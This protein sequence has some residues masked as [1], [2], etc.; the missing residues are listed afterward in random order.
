MG[1]NPKRNAEEF[2]FVDRS[3][4]EIQRSFVQQS[5]KLFVG[6]HRLCCSLT[7]ATACLHIHGYSSTVIYRRRRLAQ[8][9]AIV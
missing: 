4:Q 9:L 1:S 2:S 3:R 6:K 5:S 8:F 7:N